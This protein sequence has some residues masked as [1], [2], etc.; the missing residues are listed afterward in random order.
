MAGRRHAVDYAPRGKGQP[1]G[2]LE[3]RKIALMA[4][5]AGSRQARRAAPAAPIRVGSITRKTAV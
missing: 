4:M 1:P 3:S 5:T 2:S